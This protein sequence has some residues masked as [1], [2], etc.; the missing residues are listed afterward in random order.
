LCDCK[1]YSI[2]HIQILDLKK[3]QES[4]FELLK[5]KQRSDE[6]ANRLQAEIQYIKAQKVG[7]HSAFANFLITLI[8]SYV[9]DICPTRAFFNF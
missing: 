7:F 6:A 2:I 1:L 3:K 8:L 4:H 5:Q 9:F